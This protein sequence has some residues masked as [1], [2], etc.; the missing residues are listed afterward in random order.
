MTTLG[1]ASSTLGRLDEGLAMVQE[2][3]ATLERGGAVPELLF[4]SYSNEAVMLIDGGRYEEA[5]DVA[6]R[7]IEYTRAH[8]MERSHRSWQE[9]LLAWALFKLGRWGEA[10]ELLDETLRR[11]P[12]GIT[13]RAVQ[14]QCAA[15]DLSRGNLDSADAR[16]AD[17]V[18]SSE[19][20]QPFAA[21]RFQVEAGL[22][23]ARRELDAARAIIADGLVIVAELE[24]WHEIAWLCWRG[25][26]GRVGPRGGCPGAQAA[27]GPGRV[28]RVARPDPHA[29]GGHRRARSRASFRRCWRAA[30]PSSSAPRGGRRSTPGSLPQP[31]G[32]RS[33]SRFRAPSACC[34]SP[35]PALRS[36]VPG[37][38]SRTPS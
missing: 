17:A 28:G 10:T 24:D 30:R 3:R 20:E 35:R 34:A 13:R 4:V 8:G 25:R 36:G 12:T 14:L 16:L 2:G 1:S 7:G 21:L 19:G 15:L 37:P 33:A 22:A 26:G 6:R 38:R 5:A 9:V 27:G 29:G 31:A 18:A 23:L 32:R 11:A